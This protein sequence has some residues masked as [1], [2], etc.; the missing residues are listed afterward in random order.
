MLFSL[1][2]TG[3]GVLKSKKNLNYSK[4]VKCNPRNLLDDQLEVY[5]SILLK[6]S[7]LLFCHEIRYMRDGHWEIQCRF[8]YN[9]NRSPW[10]WIWFLGVKIK[11]MVLTIKVRPEQQLRI[12]NLIFQKI[13]CVL[14]ENSSGSTI[15]GF[16]SIMQNVNFMFGI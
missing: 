6:K 15:V 16:T 10:A 1:Q 11:K 7:R 13:Q 12:N 14:L 3:K 4:S 5:N 2:I 9:V 8:S